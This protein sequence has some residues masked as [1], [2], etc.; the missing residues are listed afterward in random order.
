MRVNV[1]RYFQGETN[2]EEIN[3]YLRK[4]SPAQT[5]KSGLFE[6]SSRA[7]VMLTSKNMY[8]IHSSSSQSAPKRPFQ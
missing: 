8:K 3:K 4:V 7:E 2:S 6:E 1:P 5:S